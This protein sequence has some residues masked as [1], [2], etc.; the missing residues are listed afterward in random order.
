MA[1]L[2]LGNIAKSCLFRHWWR[3]SND[4]VSHSIPIVIDAPSRRQMSDFSHHSNTTPP[5][6]FNAK[7]TS[8]NVL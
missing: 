6:E 7:K 4:D 8:G 1:L 5:K 3:C 2:F